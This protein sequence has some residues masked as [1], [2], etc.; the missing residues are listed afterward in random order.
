[1]AIEAIIHATRVPV[2]QSRG[3]EAKIEGLLQSLRY[4]FDVISRVSDS[5]SPE[6]QVVDSL[7]TLLEKW[8]VSI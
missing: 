4:C 5:D 7:R 8:G 3:D 6:M 2:Y 1:M